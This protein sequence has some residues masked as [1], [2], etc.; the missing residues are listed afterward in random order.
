MLEFADSFFSVSERGS[1]IGREIA[2]GIT[3]FMTLAYIIVVQPV[4][5]SSAGMDFGSVMGATCI[6]SAIACFIMGVWANYPVAIAPAMGQ[7]FYFAYTAVL[8]M[9]IPWQTVLAA[10]LA[11]G[12]I[13]FFLTVAGLREK[14]MDSMPSSLLR[15]MSAGIGL[16][17]ALVGLE[18]AGIITAH[19]GTLVGLGDL[20]SPPVILAISGLVITSVL[21]ARNVPGAILTG[22]VATTVAGIMS[23]QLHVDSVFSSP[24]SLAPTFLQ[25]D[26]SGFDSMEM[27]TVTAVF[28][29][30][31]IFDTIGTLAGVAPAAG[32]MKNGRIE[33]A[34]R[35]LLADASGTVVGAL[36][37]TSTL[38]C[39]VESAAGIQAG[40]R[41]G[42]AAIVTGLL[43]MASLFLMP[44]IDVVGGGITVSDSAV[45]YP[46]TSPALVIVGVMM[47]GAVRDIEWDRYDEAIPAF[48]TITV[49][50]FTVSIT[51]GI[52]FGLIAYS[53]LSVFTGRAGKVAWPLHACA[54]F[55]MLR[56]VFLAG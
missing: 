30:L 7:N 8:A 52:A 9:H 14:V 45:L 6:A 10:T 35:A 48:L 55:M 12:I 37:G 39:Y 43:F 36:L 27:V 51:E 49:M 32:F 38:T 4:V 44:L 46:V 53:L 13:F 17:I 34:G 40:A 24:P 41:T 15:A 42:I 33:G 18:W 54:M 31:D 20:H 22:I 3:T 19:P 50:G 2:G 21:L 26:F 28:L 25:F 11:A 23:G 56:Y 1:T 16:L 47:M 5:L 29:F